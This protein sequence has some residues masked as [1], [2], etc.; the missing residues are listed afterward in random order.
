MLTGAG[1]KDLDVLK[2][3]PFSI[4]ESNLDSVRRDL[5]QALSL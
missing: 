2:H 3:H 1:L 5:E 4:V